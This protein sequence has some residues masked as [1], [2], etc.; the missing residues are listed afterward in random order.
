MLVANNCVDSSCANGG[1][2]VFLG[3]GDGSFQPVAI[4]G[5]GG[6]GAESIALTDVNSDGKPDLVVANQCSSGTCVDGNVALFLGNGNGTFRLGITYNSG[7]HYAVSVTVADVNRDGKADVL[8]LNQCSEGGACET[9]SASVLTGNGNGTFQAAASFAPGGPYAYS[10]AAGDVNGDGKLDL[11]VADQLTSGTV[12]LIG[13]LLGNADGTFQAAS[14]YSSG[15]QSWAYSVTIA[16]V[17]QD[18]KPDVLVGNYDGT[19]GVLLG[20][21]DGTFR[22]GVAYGSGGNYAYSIAVA[23][24]VTAFPTCW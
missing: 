18:G 23:D 5:S 14:S 16:D 9:G 17:N 4:Y 21:G 10:I 8:A 11:V 2:G 19:V 1:I 7:G 20:N 13:V 24:A 3:I 15:G 12:G 22:A 6:Q